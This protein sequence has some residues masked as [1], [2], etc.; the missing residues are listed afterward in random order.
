[1]DVPVNTTFTVL[2]QEA[3]HN[4][5]LSAGGL[6]SSY[7]S[8]P[9]SDGP[10]CDQSRLKLPYSAASVSNATGI[11]GTTVTADSAGQAVVGGPAAKG[12]AVLALVAAGVA[13]LL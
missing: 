10:A 4:G 5:N 11:I 13:V 6:S 1:M 3:A 12:A 2:Y 9:P 7:I 8:V